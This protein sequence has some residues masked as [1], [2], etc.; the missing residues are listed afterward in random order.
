MKNPNVAIAHGIGMVHQHFM[1]VDNFTVTQNI[2]L[3]QETTR[4]GA[5]WI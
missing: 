5:W 1:L 3:G 4:A 2:I